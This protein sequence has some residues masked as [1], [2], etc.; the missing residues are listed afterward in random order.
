MGIFS[1]LGGHRNDPIDTKAREH[2]RRAQLYHNEKQTRAAIDEYKRALSLDSKPGD[3]HYGL[4]RC[5]HDLARDANMRARGNI[6]FKA[7]LEQL[8]LAITE[9]EIAVRDQPEAA[10]ANISLALAY[11]NR[12]RLEDAERFYRKAIALDPDGL[13]GLDA[14]C[15][16]ALL[17][18]MR[19]LGWA[20]LK[21]FPGWATVDRESPL[22]QAALAEA[23]EG[24]ALGERLVL[25]H[26]E[27]LPSLIDQH[28]RYAEWC[29]KCMWGQRASEHVQAIL[30]LD[31][32]DAEARKWLAKAEKNTGR[33]LL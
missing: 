8:D 14:H 15:N 2:V 3:A 21:E 10:D 19:G 16:L 6:Y 27:C 26:P 23:D 9:L 24:I 22:M 28:R 31:P 32:K 12:G 17:L 18:W 11:D 33:K 29:T 4:G 20:G 5:Y 30:R 25:K 13:D 1:K 7:G